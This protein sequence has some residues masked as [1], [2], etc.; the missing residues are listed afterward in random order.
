MK[1]LRINLT[2]NQAIQL[3][4]YFDRVRTAYVSGSPGMLIAQIC[5]NDAEGKCWME[6]A[7]LAHEHA[8]LITEKGET[9]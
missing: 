3:A 2:S 7:F 4:A 8:K 5:W 9:A 6:P 1:R